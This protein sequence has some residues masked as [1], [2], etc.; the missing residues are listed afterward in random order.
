MTRRLL[1]RLE[2]YCRVDLEELDIRNNPAYSRFVRSDEYR[3]WMVSRREKE[4]SASA[5]SE[6]RSE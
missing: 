2:K 6:N 5:G 3:E 4:R 1:R